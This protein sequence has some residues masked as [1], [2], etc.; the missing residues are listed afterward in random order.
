[1]PKYVK[2]RQLPES[3]RKTGENLLPFDFLGRLDV[4]YALLW[5]IDSLSSKLSNCMLRAQ[6]WGLH[7]TLRHTLVKDNAV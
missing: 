2:Y 5:E 1:M 6:E 7:A 3:V 4:S